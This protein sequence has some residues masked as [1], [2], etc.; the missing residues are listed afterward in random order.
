MKGTPQE[1]ALLSRSML[2]R[3]QKCFCTEPS[4][5]RLRHD[6]GWHREGFTKNSHSALINTPE[7]IQ[8]FLQPCSSKGSTTKVALEESAPLHLPQS[9]KCLHKMQHR[10]SHVIFHTETPFVPHPESQG[11]PQSL[12]YPSLRWAV[13]LQGYRYTRCGAPVHH[14]RF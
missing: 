14:N 2:E 9:M 3:G 7:V 11:A 8:M 4:R 1:R 13:P 10:R 6:W 5:Q 12:R